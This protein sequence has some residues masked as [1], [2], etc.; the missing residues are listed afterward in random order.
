MYKF[1]TEK[2]LKIVENIICMLYCSSWDN[3]DSIVNSLEVGKS[4]VQILAG[5]FSS[6]KCPHW[7]WGFPGICSLGTCWRDLPLGVYQLA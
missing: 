2:Q 4:V 1:F 7:L 3:I 6:A 5:F